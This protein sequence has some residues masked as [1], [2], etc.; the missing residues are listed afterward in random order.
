MEINDNN[1][2]ENKDS[3]IDNVIGQIK[4]D[5]PQ[6]GKSILFDTII[7][8]LYDMITDALSMLIYKDYRLGRDSKSSSNDNSRIRYDRVLTSTVRGSRNR[9]RS[10]TRNTESI[11]DRGFQYRDIVYEYRDDALDVLERIKRRMRNNGSV[12]IGFMY[13]VYN[14]VVRPKT[15][16]A[17][18]HTYNNWGWIINTDSD[19]YDADVKKTPSGYYY[20]DLPDPDQIK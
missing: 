13:D 4:R 1:Q 6:T 7:P 15:T 17:Y 16:M 12:S 2:N 8:N 9:N 20:I 19:L 5:L 11:E 18:H 3:R 10:I 14:D